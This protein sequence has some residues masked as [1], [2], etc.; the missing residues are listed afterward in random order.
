MARTDEERFKVQY[1]RLKREAEQRKLA[2]QEKI[3]LAR[4]VRVPIVIRRPVQRLPVRRPVQ[5]P[6][7]R[8]P[9]LKRRGFWYSWGFYFKDGVRTFKQRR[10]I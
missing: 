7:V 1:M 5:I 10:R 8:K 3:K 9:I 6:Q 2:E 4:K